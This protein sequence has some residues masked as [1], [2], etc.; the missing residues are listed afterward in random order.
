M[1]GVVLNCI[2]LI[3]NKLTHLQRFKITRMSANRDL[4]QKLSS[5]VRYLLQA[6]SDGRD[7]AHP[8]GES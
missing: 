4:V 5:D 3:K 2:I 7:W 8:T 1:W 6:L